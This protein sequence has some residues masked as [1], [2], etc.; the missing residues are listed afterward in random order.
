MSEFPGSLL[1]SASPAATTSNTSQPQRRGCVPAAGVN[2][3]NY[4]CSF[5]S[6]GSLCS[7]FPARSFANLIALWIDFVGFFFNSEQDGETKMGRKK[8]GC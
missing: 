1:P 7:Q 3:S 6:S 4:T 2:Y 5:F 8:S